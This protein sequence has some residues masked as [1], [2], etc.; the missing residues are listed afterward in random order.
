[1]GL[2]RPPKIITCDV[3]QIPRF[4]ACVSL[5]MR[6]KFQAALEA[7]V[8]SPKHAPLCPNRADARPRP[9]NPLASRQAGF[10]SCGN[11]KALP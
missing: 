10:L 2:Y 8:R 7:N 3:A 1:M 4:F 11:R 9:M 5:E 6:A